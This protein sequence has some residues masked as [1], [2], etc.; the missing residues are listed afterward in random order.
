MEVAALIARLKTATVSTATAAFFASLSAILPATEKTILP[1]GE[2]AITAV[3]ASAT[4]GITPTPF[5]KPLIQLLTSIRLTCSIVS[6]FDCPA[7]GG[8]IIYGEHHAG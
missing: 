5:G 1:T 6:R 8:Y 4:H 7:S 2:A 3:P